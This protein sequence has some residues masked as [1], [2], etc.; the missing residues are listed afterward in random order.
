[1][2]FL[3]G[4]PGNTQAVAEGVVLQGTLAALVADR[5][6]Q[7]VIRQQQLDDTVLSGDDLG[8]VGVHHHVGADGCGACRL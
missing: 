7:G 6:V 3:F 2:A 8:R 4:E 1:V 5:A